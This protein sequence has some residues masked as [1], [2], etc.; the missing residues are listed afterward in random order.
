MRSLL[1]KKQKSF[2]RQAL[3]ALL[4]C[5]DNVIQI[6]EKIIN[7]LRHRRRDAVFLS[8]ARQSVSILSSANLTERSIFF[9]KKPYEKLTLTGL[10]LRG[11][12]D[13]I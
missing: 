3:K 5:S 2:E 11:C 7:N 4:F 8:S 1:R 6:T 9:P 12:I 13:L 10:F